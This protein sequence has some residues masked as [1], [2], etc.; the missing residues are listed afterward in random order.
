MAQVAPGPHPQHSGVGARGIV[1]GSPHKETVR[2]ADLW[3]PLSSCIREK[4]SLLLGTLSRKLLSNFPFD[5]ANGNV[6]RRGP[7]FVE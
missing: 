7:V 2:R 6:K 3:R 1:G 5:G 4:H